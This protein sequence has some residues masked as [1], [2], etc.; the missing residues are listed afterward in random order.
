MPVVSGSEDPGSL[1]SWM[2][3]EYNEKVGYLSNLRRC[4]AEEMLP[5]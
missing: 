1:Y 2:T 5:V 3:I 4:V